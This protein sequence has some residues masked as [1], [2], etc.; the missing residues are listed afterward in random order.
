MADDDRTTTG[1]GKQALHGGADSDGRGVFTVGTVAAIGEKHGKF[2]RSLPSDTDSTN[3]S[4][5][6]GKD[7]YEY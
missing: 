1:E 7:K 2:D 4:T 5:V 6:V 3:L